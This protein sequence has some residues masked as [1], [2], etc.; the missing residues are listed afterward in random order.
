MGLAFLNICTCPLRSRDLLYLYS[1]RLR[2]VV[3][4]ERTDRPNLVYIS[5][6]STR[7]QNVTWSFSFHNE[8]A[9]SGP[10]PPH[11]RRFTIKLRHNTLG[12][13]NLDE[14]SARRRDLYL[15]TNNISKRQ[16]S[17]PPAGFE[18]AIPASERPQNLHPLGSEVVSDRGRE[19]YA[20]TEKKVV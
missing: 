8:I 1:P 15:T 17:M 3:V 12:R 5:M 16:I 9:P 18:P 19:L 10:G 4:T 20:G 14:W 2:S 13:T 7:T 11:C 6:M